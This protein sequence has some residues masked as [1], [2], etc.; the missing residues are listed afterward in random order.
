M[1]N[2]MRN[3][4]HYSKENGLSVPQIG[5]LFRVFHK[6]NSGVTDISEELAITCAAASQMLE[7]LVQQGLILRS[8]DPTDRRMKQ[9]VLTDKGRQ[10]LQDSIQARQA[11]MD[12]LAYLLS[13]DEKEQ[14]VAALNILISKAHL[15]ERQPELRS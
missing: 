1:H 12:K 13:P 14:V 7:R 3:F 9:I 5:A 15:L 11:W 6:G 2:S 10:V 4:I 8:E